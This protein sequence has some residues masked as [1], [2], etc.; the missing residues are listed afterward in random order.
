MT[1]L[2]QYRIEAAQRRRARA[3]RRGGASRAARSRPEQRLPSV[4][5]LAA[6][7]RA[8]PGRP[9][10]PGSPSCAAAA[11]SS[12][13]SGA[14]RGSAQAPPIGSRADADAG[15]APAPATSRAATPTRRCCP[16]SPRA[17]ARAELPVRL[18]GE[19]PPL[20]ELAA[21]AREQLRADGRSGRGAVRR[22]RRARRD[23]AGARRS[24]CDRATASRSR[25]PG[26]AALFDLLRALGLALEPVAVDE[27]GMLP[28][29][30]EAALERGARAVIITPRGQ[31]PTGAALDARA[32]TA[33]CAPCS[34]AFRDALV[35]ED[36]HLGAVAGSELHTHRRRPRALG[37]DALGRQGARPRPAPG[38][39]RGRR[40]HDRPRAGAPAVRARLGQPHPADARARRCGPTRRCRGRSRA[41]ARPTPSGA[42]ASWSACASRGVQAHGASGLNVWVPVPEE[43]ARRRSAAAARL[44]GRARSALPARRAARPRSASRSRRSTDARGRAAGAAISPRC[45]RRRASS[46]SG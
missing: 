5:R 43:A 9:S 28:A 23:R 30:L 4:R 16:I 34:P 12:P 22:Q 11:S 33:S 14:A 35:I 36:D 39:A 26:Y 8:Q 46:R 38:G 18:Y 20:P 13:S 2:K 31:N 45:S 25:T 29:A 42:S 6:R 17:L 15:A 24:T 44:G 32:C 27:R 1:E 40:A 10:P 41:R 19:P 3:Q 21:L 37:G 7:G